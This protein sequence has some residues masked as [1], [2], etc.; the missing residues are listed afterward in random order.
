VRRDLAIHQPFEQSDRAVSRVACG[1][2]GRK[3]EAKTARTK[4]RIPII[5]PAQAAIP[6]RK[7]FAIHSGLKIRPSTLRGDLT[8]FCA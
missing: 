4:Q 2:S 6:S 3:G 5:P 1:T 7:R 8:R